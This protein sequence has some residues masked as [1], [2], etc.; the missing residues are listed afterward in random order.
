MDE[1]AVL[2]EL[3]EAY[4]PSGEED[5]AVRAFVRLAKGLGLAT[6][7]DEAGNAFARR[8]SGKPQILFLGHI[9]TVEGDL[10]V[11]V[12]EGRIT[13][14]GACDAK[15]ALA[16]ALLAGARF[17]GPGELLIA[18]AVGEEKDSR[19]ARH[20]IPRHAP[21]FL[22]V[23]EPSG[24]DAVTIG[25]KGNVALT[26]TFEGERAHLSSPGATTVET[27][28]A[29]VHRLREFCWDRRGETPFTS[30]T[31]K[32]HTITTRRVGGREVVE[33]SVNL[34]LPQRVRVAD[35]VR[36]LEENEMAG[37]HRITDSSEAVEVDRN[38]PVVRALRVA[39]RHHGGAPRLLR[40]AGTSDLN[41]AGP[42][43][44]CP[45]AVYGPG[46]AHLD[47]TDRE[48]LPIR[49]LQA[50]TR[51]LESAFLALSASTPAPAPPAAMTPRLPAPRVARRR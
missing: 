30:L 15:G 6:R 29:F 31:A 25:Y 33:V 16:A 14:R 37:R 41:L 20:L 7:V 26:L 27:A 34:R 18:A 35:V 9:D 51:V 11:A 23:G 48:S 47:H 13:G 32:V 19:G 5:A 1:T 50:S 2:R 17:T 3:L 43:W 40:K 45:A 22:V 21:D 28:L 46:D 8:G 10:P 42:V 12:K 38:N 44:G 24:W 36:F 4:S 49:E 39:I